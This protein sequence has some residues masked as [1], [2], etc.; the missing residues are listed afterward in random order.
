MSDFSFTSTA[1]CAY[2]GNMLSSSDEECDQC[3]ESDR[4]RQMFRHMTGDDDCPKTVVVEATHRHKWYK[5]ADKMGKDWI[6]YEWI[7]PMEEVKVFIN[8]TCD[9]IDDVPR[10][11]TSLDAP[12][13]VDKP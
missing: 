7:G 11:S 10:R 2:C 4:Y 12:N 9:S 8:S 1:E 5:L 3:D 6:A 13:E